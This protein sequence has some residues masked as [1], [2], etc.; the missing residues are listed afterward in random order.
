MLHHRVDQLHVRQGRIV[1]PEFGERRAFFTQQLARGDTGPRDQAFQHRARG[2]RL[3]IFDDVRLDPGIADHGERVARGPAFG[4]VIDDDD[5]GHWASPSLAC[6]LVL[7]PSSR[8]ISAS[9]L[10]IAISSM[11]S[12]EHTSELQSLMR[13]SYAV[14]CLKKKIYTSI[15]RTNHSKTII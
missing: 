1:E 10:R 9:L 12:E 6:A 14:F 8:P 7:A 2:R 3:E 11:R 15:T 5:E 4:I 13:I